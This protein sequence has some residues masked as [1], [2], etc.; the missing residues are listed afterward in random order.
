M[1][2]GFDNLKN[3]LNLWSAE[4]VSQAKANLKDGGKGGGALEKSIKATVSDTGDG[5]EVKF[6]MLNYGAFMDMGVKGAGGTIKTGDH[7]GSWGGRRYFINYKGKRKDSPFQFGSGKS[8]GS[9]N[10]GIEKYIRKKGIKPTKG[11]VEGLRYAMV[12]VLWTKGIHGISFFQN[13]LMLGLRNFPEDMGVEIKEDII[14]T[15]VTF[16]GISRP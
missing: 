12:K 15:M 3:Y 11:T 2:I 13:S 7:A 14:N 6:S 10:K 1:P 4:V 9:I 5:Y 16:D 8:S